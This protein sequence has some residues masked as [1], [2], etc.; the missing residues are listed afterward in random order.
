MFLRVDAGL[1]LDCRLTAQRNDKLQMTDDK[2][3]WLT[4]RLALANLS[5]VICHLS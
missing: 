1:T 2:F 3:L 4:L 5:S